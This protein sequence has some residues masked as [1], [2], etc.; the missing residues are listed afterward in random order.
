MKR[1]RYVGGAEK[2]SALNVERQLSDF[3]SIVLITMMVSMT[4]RENQYKQHT[5]NMLFLK[6]FPFLFAALA[7]CCKSEI[8][9]YSY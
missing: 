9:S 6:Y 8:Q 2:H 5:P 4:I 7:H 3:V 1:S